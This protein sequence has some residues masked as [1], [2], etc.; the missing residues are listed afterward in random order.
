MTESKGKGKG[1]NGKK[2]KEISKGKATGKNDKGKGKEKG[3]PWEEERDDEWQA[4]GKGKGRAKDDW[5]EGKEYEDAL[6]DL[7]N[8]TALQM[9]DFDLWMVKLLDALQFAGKA[10]EAINILKE[11]LADR[12]RDQMRNPRAYMFALL[13]KF[14]KDVQTSQKLPNGFKSDFNVDAPEFVPTPPSNNSLTTFSIDAPEFVPTGKI[15]SS[16]SIDAPE[17]VPSSFSTAI[18]SSSPNTPDMRPS[19]SPCYTPEKTYLGQAFDGAASFEKP[20]VPTF[21]S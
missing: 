11:N 9:T 14:K 19:A 1:K 8:T 6:T 20:A 15:Q 10:E 7:I 3:K 4:K 16:F 18:A 17:F 12:T 2:S 5:L 13:T 21:V